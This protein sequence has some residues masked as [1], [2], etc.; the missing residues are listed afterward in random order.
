MTAAT[1]LKLATLISYGMGLVNAAHAVMNVRS[2]RGAIAW[3]IALITF[4]WLTIPLYWIF[5]RAKF[6]GYAEALHRA[7][8]EHHA[9]VHQA[10]NEVFKF[11]VD[12]PN[13]LK[14]LQK[15]A[16]HF[17]PIP[18]T[19]GNTVEL[20]INGEQTYAAML[21]A[22]AAARQYIL[23]QSYSITDDH[24][25]QQFSQAL[26]TQ[27]Q[28]GIRIYLLYDGLGSWE[29]SSAYLQ[30]LQNHGIH[31]GVFKSTKGK[32][33]RFQLNFRNHR[34]ILIVDGASAFVGGINIGDLYRGQVAP[35]SP[36]RD[37]HLRVQGAAVQCLQ[38]VFLGDWFWAT[39]TILTVCWQVKT[40]AA[41]NQ[42]VFVLPTG[43]ADRLPTCTLFFV[44]AINQAQSRLWI[45]SPYFVPDEAILTAL[46]LAAL[47][48]VDVRIILPNQPDHFWVYLCSFS[49]YTELQAVGIKLYRYQPGFM[50]QKVM[51]IDDTIAAVGTVNLDHR[52]F[53][54]NFEVTVFVIQVQ[55]VQA[56][57]TM[58]EQDLTLTRRIESDEYDRRSLGFK[59]VTKI[60]RL[61]EPIL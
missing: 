60:A 50:H 6:N 4:P 36:W 44:N 54:L 30:A 23:L 55:F 51:L 18:F 32:G 27:A 34:K 14:T 22:I 57:A 47:R 3:S 12:L 37:T 11:K 46:K 38:S 41:Q 53:F 31:V 26:I 10:Y 48:G 59:L 16:E 56:V 39:R 19:S 2:S 52:S 13:N 15:L 35:L 21:G 45:A 49:Y 29:L 8:R 24:I 28:R 7:D 33:N 9:A 43:P 17:H 42:T 5:G 61:L 58:L 40:V 1:L 20:L 25:G